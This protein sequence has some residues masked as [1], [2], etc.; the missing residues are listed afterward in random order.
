MT[1]CIAGL[2]LSLRGTGAVVVPTSWK[3]SGFDWSVVVAQKFGHPLS[4]DA[5]QLK[6]IDRLISIA[7]GVV[8]FCLT[9]DV[10]NVWIEHYA[11]GARFGGPILG[12]LGGAVKLELRKAGVRKISVVH[13]SS[14]RKTLLGKVPRVDQKRTV[15]RLLQRLEAPFA[16]DGDLVDAFVVANHGMSM[17]GFCAMMVG[18]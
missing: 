5:S 9:N 6:K 4:E 3:R 17:A 8:A 12:E 16:K 18:E 7:N 10:R 1:K 15:Q 11:F 2:D 14:A 13:S